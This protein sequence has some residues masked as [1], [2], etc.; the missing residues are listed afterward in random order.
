MHALH[1]ELHGPWISLQSLSFIDH[2]SGL[3][4]SCASLGEN[5]NPSAF[6]SAPEAPH[7]CGLDMILSADSR[8]LLLFVATNTSRI[9]AVVKCQEEDDREFAHH[10]LILSSK[11]SETLH[12]S[13]FRLLNLFKR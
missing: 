13:A 6:S 11:V 3:N 2:H 1:S 9:L 12:F 5:T 10:F 4:A 7:V 8:T